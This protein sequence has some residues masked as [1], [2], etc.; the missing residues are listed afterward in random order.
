M[1]NGLIQYKTAPNNAIASGDRVAV[2]AVSGTILNVHG[3]VIMTDGTGGDFRW[4][5]SAGGDAL[6][7]I[8]VLPAG[9]SLVLPFSEVPWFSTVAGEALVMEVGLGQIDGHVIYSESS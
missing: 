4:E 5:S 7:G 9:S 1:A 3:Y 6:S 2:A 8:F